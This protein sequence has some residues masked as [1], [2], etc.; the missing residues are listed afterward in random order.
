MG[1]DTGVGD[2]VPADSCWVL[3]DP[4]VGV[5][6]A[7]LTLLEQ[8]GEPDPDP[9]LFTPTYTFF[10]GPEGSFRD[11]DTTGWW[12][13]IGGSCVW[14]AKARAS[15]VVAAAAWSGAWTSGVQMMGVGD[16]GPE[17]GFRL[18]WISCVH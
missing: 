10:G 14:W 15:G 13:R 12:K 2:T 1:W 5:S 3:K 8:V 18:V 16:G 4:R 17:D 11:P 7:A 6:R 9:Q